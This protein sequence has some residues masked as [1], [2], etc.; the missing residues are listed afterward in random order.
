LAG[1]LRVFLHHGDA[2]SRH[3]A[4]GLTPGEAEGEEG[5]AQRCET[6]NR[7]GE[8]PSS[9]TFRGKATLARKP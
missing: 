5:E 4:R 1:A 6:A 8:Q 2:L 3:A 7:W 9:P